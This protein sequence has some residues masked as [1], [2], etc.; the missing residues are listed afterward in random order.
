MA[1]SKKKTTPK[2]RAAAGKTGSKGASGKRSASQKKPDYTNRV[3]AG[4]V[5]FALAVFSAFGYFGIKAVLIDLLVNLERG[6][7]GYGYWVTPIMF[8]W[9]SIIFLFHKGMP[10]KLRV[11]FALLVP[12]LV[13]A[14]VQSFLWE[15]PYVMSLSIVPTMWTTGLEMTSGGLLGGL[16]AALLVTALSRV[17]AIPVCL[18]LLVVAFFIITRKTPSDVAHAYRAASERHQE[19][20]ALREAQREEEA[21]YQP[22][23]ASRQREPLPLRQNPVHKTGHHSPAID[24]PVDEAGE[25]VYQPASQL[26]SSAPTGAESV[27]RP[28]DKPFFEE[29]KG[30]RFFDRFF[31]EPEVEEPARDYR[32]AVTASTPRPETEP[33]N[34]M[35]LFRPQKTPDKPAAAPVPEAAALQPEEP[36]LL[37]VSP[38]EKKA[39]AQREKQERELAAA[40]V[41]EEL[42]EGLQKLEA[43]LHPPLELLGQAAGVSMDAAQGELK[44]IGARLDD[45]IQAF[46]IDAHVVGAVRGPTVTRYELELERGVKL[47][48]VTNL[49]DDIALTLGA[50][51]V[52]IA[53]IPGKSLV[54]GVE[55]PNRL[56]SPVPI[57]EVIGGDEF[58]NH[59]SNVAFALGKDI[60]GKN[61]V[62]NIAKLPHMLIA[63]TTGSGKSVCTNS[64]IISLLYKSSPEQVRLIMI[65]PKMVELSVYN[66]IPHLLIPVVTDPKKAAGSLQ[67]AVTE[68]LKRYRLFSERHVRDLE[69]YNQQV[70]ADPESGEKTLPQIVIFI[71]ELADLMLVASKEVEEAICRLAQMGRASGMHLI[72]ATQRPSTDVIT[73]LMKANIPSIIALS[74]ASG[75]ES[76]IILDTQGAEKLVGNGDMLFSPVGTGKPQRV[77]GCFISD[78]EVAAVAEFIKQHSERSTTPNRPARTARKAAPRSP[79]A[80]FPKPPTAP[81]PKTA[82]PF[83]MR[84]SLSWWRP[85]WPPSPCSSVGSSW[86]MPGLPAWWTRWRKRAL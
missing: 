79:T 46:G 3:V 25:T 42:E 28:S 9:T 51:S 36:Q 54:V 2:S 64:I 57:R 18:L 21:Q 17:G 10:I 77:Q 65:D 81:V 86:A 43:Y 72:I 6:L 59:K 67:W 35:D 8:L 71:D 78:E 80:P 58:Q 16:F 33:E 73:G 66:G 12:G 47:S 5:F 50:K 41:A 63:G 56:V 76:R 83:S 1:E 29:K 4:C 27:F 11:S 38:S 61:V 24:I 26:P 85:V 13:G 55:V 32:P 22:Q 39:A 62:G 69:S 52:R 84:L 70:E 68:M 31:R 14:L 44:E 48:R 7:V 40:Q 82:T 49:A 75:L 23:P 74:V 37:P 53:P 34:P 20:K 30:E 19:K 45:T 60:S 15:D